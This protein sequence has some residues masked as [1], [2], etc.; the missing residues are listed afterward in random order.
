MALTKCKECG[1]EISRNADKCPSCGSPQKKKTSRL[2]WLFLILIIIVV[3]VSMNPSTPS[4]TQN[5]SAASKL[6][7][8][9]AKQAERK[10]F[11]EKLIKNGILYKVEVP[12]ELPHIYVSSGFYSLNVDDKQSFINVVYAYYLAQN[13]RANIATLHDSKSGKQIGMFT[14]RGLDLD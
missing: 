6:D 8:S 13:P 9:P 7:E 11:I 3:Y 2:T 1:K 5:S 10:L 12:A 14:G 4:A